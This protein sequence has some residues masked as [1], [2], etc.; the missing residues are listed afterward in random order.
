MVEERSAVGV[1]GEGPAGGVDDEALLMFLGPDLP[2]LL[3]PDA[4]DL[5]IDACAQRKTLLQPPPEMA[6][7]AFGEKRVLRAQLH[8]WLIGIGGLAVAR[9][10]HVSGHHAPDASFCSIEHLRPGKAGEDF[11]PESFGLLREPAAHVGEAHHVIA[12]IAEARRQQEARH[13]PG[14]LLREEEEPVLAHGR[15]ERR[16]EFLPGRDEFI[17][18]PRVHDGA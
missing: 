7:A 4:V 17:E 11:D 5:G 2:Q 14:L 12:V 1:V 15:V 13:L 8:S 10:A 3:Q 18:R 9:D 16:V 6:A